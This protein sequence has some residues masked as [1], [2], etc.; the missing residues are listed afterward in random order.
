MQVRNKSPASG[1]GGESVVGIQL[2]LHI[3]AVNEPPQSFT[4]HKLSQ[5]PIIAFTFKTLLR[6]YAEQVLTHGK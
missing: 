4:V 3:R 5:G 1:R 6:H 2:S